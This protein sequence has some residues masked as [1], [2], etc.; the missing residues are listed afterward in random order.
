MP[1]TYNATLTGTLGGLTHTVALNFVIVAPIPGATPVNLAS[2]YNRTGIYT[3][4]RSFS[5]RRRRQLCRIF[6]QSA[7][8]DAFLERSGFQSGTVQCG[9]CGLLRE[10][11]HHLPAGR[12]N[13]LQIL[14]TGVQGN[15]AAQTFTITYTDNSTATFTQSFS[16]WANPQVTRRNAVITMPYRN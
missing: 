3:D 9:G 12:F 10:P 13:T 14:A 2:Y 6:R 4:G 8:F 15:Q 11:D 7:R 1:G 5:R 16:D